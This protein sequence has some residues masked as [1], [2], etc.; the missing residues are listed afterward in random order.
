MVRVRM[1][2]AALGAAL[3]ISASAC[4]SSSSSSS[5]SSDAA[6][7]GSS[8]S[9]GVASVS[10]TTVAATGSATQGITTSAASGLHQQAPASIAKANKIVFCSDISYPPEEFYDGTTPVGSDIEIGTAIGKQMN[11]KAEFDNTGFD[12]IIP[13]LLS[14][15]C[16]A[17]ISGMNDTPERAKQV[18]FV[19]YLSVGQAFMVKK[20]NPDKIDGL[21][22]IAGRTVSVEV[23]TTNA[24]F[25]KAQSAKLVAAG[26]K[27]V[28]VQT[29]PKDTDAAN[30]LRSGKV[31]AYFGDAPVVAYYV[32]KTPDAFA[33]GGNAVN[34][35]AVGIAV[36]KGDE[37]KAAIAGAVKNL[38]SDGTMTKILA[39]WE[40]SDMG[41]K[42]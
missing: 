11:V 10:A 17:I 3:V 34:P 15:K 24:D 8:V 22:A 20:G 4:G 18:D 30:A 39:K 41:L 9:L 12:G 21:D 26:K 42:S 14:K 2:G 7:G 33:F 27:A 40:M 37:L 1:V 28:T 31:D 35:I 29:F 16:D 38:Y 5:S 13:A 6:A 36:R 25:L 32:K 23:G 19:D